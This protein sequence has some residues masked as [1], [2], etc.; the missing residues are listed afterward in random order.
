MSKAP[1]ASTIVAISLIPAAF[2]YIYSFIGQKKYSKYHVTTGILAIALDL[3]ISI[4][5]MIYRS[6][7]G[8]VNGQA[9]HPTGFMLKFFM[10]HGIFSAFVM[11]LEIIALIQG[12][13]YLRN[14][15]KPNETF[16]ISTLLF[17]TWWF[18]FLSGE[19]LYIINYFF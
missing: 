6:I 9:L 18:A 1:L 16:K 5:Y 8:K 19:I 17:I 4:G 7:G 13:N 14:R 2:L 15:L 10:V 12:I 3:C 11:V